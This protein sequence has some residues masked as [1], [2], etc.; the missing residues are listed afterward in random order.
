MSEDGANAYPANIQP[1]VG[2]ILGGGEI[3]GRFGHTIHIDRRRQIIFVDRTVSKSL[4][5]AINGDGTGIDYSLDVS[6]PG[7]LKNIVG[8]LNVDQHTKVR[9]VFGIRRQ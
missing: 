1:I 5:H 8:P 9:P 2:A 6:P 3:V 4:L 7:N